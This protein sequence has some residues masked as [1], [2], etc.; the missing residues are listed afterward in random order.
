MKWQVVK[1]MGPWVWVDIDNQQFQVRFYNVRSKHDIEWYAN[2]FR[3][4]LAKLAGPRGNDLEGGDD[5]T[6]AVCDV[7]GGSGGG[8]E[9]PLK[10]TFCFGSGA[11]SEVHEVETTALPPPLLDCT[12]EIVYTSC[13]CAEE[14][15]ED[16]G[17]CPRCHEHS[18]PMRMCDVHQK[19]E[20]R[21]DL[22]LGGGDEG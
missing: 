16:V 10:C 8:P 22:L 2:Q 4:A 18:V 14:Y 19:D 1:G 3:A 5:P 6:R 17:Y 13:G 7:C 11:G 21:E 9:P 12:C 15:D 20:V